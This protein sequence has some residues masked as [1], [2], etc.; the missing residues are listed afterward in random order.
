MIVSTGQS[1]LQ[2]PIAMLSVYRPTVEHQ[3]VMLQVSD[4][5]PL[6]SVYPQRCSVLQVF[7]MASNM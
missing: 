7:G 4:P 5:V 1:R 2:T 6:S 3:F